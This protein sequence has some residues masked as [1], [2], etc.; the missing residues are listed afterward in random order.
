[1]VTRQQRNH[2]PL[3][4]TGWLDT[5]RIASGSPAMWREIIMTNRKA[6]LAALDDADEA[7]MKLRDLIEVGDGPGI[8][9][10]LAA[11]KKRRD[12]MLSQRFPPQQ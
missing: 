2:L 12:A 6:V 1:M 3:A 8:Q 11:A 4:G 7:L 10:Y 9:R 5:T